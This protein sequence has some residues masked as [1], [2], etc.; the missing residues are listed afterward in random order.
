MS[1]DL[2]TFEIVK[3]AALGLALAAAVGL[4]IFVPF[5]ALSLASLA[6]VVHLGPGMA[7]I[8][9][10]PALIAFGVAAAV[11]LAAYKVPWLDNTLD[12]AGAPIAILAGGVLAAAVVPAADPLL[13]WT[14]VAVTGGAA[15]GTVHLSMA[16]VRKL[17]SLT[18]G[19]LANIVIA[20]AEAVGAFLLSVT[21]IL[22]PLLAATAAALLLL[23]LA[24]VVRRL[25]A[26]RDVT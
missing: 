3:A 17:S 1:G 6:N 18:T 8:G 10:V 12:A 2:T 14:L 4:R 13:R 20:V 23:A 24:L 16:A 7:W 22:L 5:L 26:R 11:E 9:S 25:L 21:A 15:A 19:G